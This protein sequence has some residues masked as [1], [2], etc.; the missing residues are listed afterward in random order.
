MRVETSEPS[1]SNVRASIDS[2]L[3]A[4]EVRR[5]DTELRVGATVLLDGDA[6]RTAT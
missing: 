3:T 4:G 6:F 2:E 5:T 1:G